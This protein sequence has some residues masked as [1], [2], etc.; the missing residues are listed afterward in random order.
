MSFV[1]GID[2]GG[3]A[4]KLGLV[5]LPLS[6]T[7]TSTLTSSSP[8]S[9]S[10][11]ARAPPA[12]PPPPPNDPLLH[13]LRA[14][15]PPSREDR[16]PSAIVALLAEACRRL[17]AEAAAGGPF[18]A[19]Q[20]MVSAIGLGFPGHIKAGGIA[21]GAANLCSTWKDVPLAALLAAKL[22]EQEHGPGSRSSRSTTSTIPILLLNDADSALAAEAWQGAA[23]GEKNVVM[24][25]LGYVP[26]GVCVRRACACMHYSPTPPRPY[27]T[28]GRA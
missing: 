14:P 6:S 1:I 5:S 8:P 4:A 7:S 24:L 12:A 10:Q 11:A 27:P 2:L 28:I 26:G 23:K 16:T 25:T 9:E 21:A 22:A 17:L 20:P 18:D 19:R 13:T 15:L 3:T